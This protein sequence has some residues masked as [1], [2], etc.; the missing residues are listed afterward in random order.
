MG[1][2]RAG[3]APP[4]SKPSAAA[5]TNRFIMFNSS[6]PDF[7]RR[8]SPGPRIQHEPSIL[9]REGAISSFF[10]KNAATNC[11][12][13]ASTDRTRRLSL[14]QPPKLNPPGGSQRDRD[15]NGDAI[16]IEGSLQSCAQILSCQEQR[17]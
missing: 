13:A 12:S 4:K 11:S 14:T 10:P 9:N 3:A 8:P 5:A 15:G 16:S 17:E 2:A 1:P 7:P 6:E